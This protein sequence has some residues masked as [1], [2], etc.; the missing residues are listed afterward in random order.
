MSSQPA[1]IHIVDDDV[2]FRTA[3][4]RLLRSHG[5]HVISYKSAKQVLE[6]IPSVE[7]GCILLDLKMS[8]ISG[9]E[10]QD[11]LAKLQNPLPIIFVTGHGDIQTSVRAIKGGAEDYIIK[12]VAEKILLEVVERALKRSVESCRKFTRNGSL[13]VLFS[14]LTEREKKVVVLV[15][16][17]RLNKQ[18]AYELG[19]SIRTVK[20]HRHNAMEKLKVGSIA[21]LVSIAKD[22]GMEVA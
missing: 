22:L 5:Y 17:G 14:A 2:S 19:T 10:L 21:G 16:R 18:I 6:K 12:P 13:R 4:G 7:H 3:I 8:R 15:A 1:V 9:M 11:E 20:N